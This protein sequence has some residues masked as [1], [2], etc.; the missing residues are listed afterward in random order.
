MLEAQEHGCEPL[1]V[2]DSKAA[3]E[4]LAR[5][6]VLR[7][8]ELGKGLVVQRLV[9]EGGVEQALGL[10]LEWCLRRKAQRGDVLGEAQPRLE[11]PEIVGHPAKDH[12]RLDDL[13]PRPLDPLVVAQE[14][15]A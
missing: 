8:T 13:L 5:Q 6:A 11:K 2:L 7:P 15:L 3:H 10:T 14:F 4:L 12:V 1:P 9:G